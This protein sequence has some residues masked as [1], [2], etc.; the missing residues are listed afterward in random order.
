MKQLLAA[1]ANFQQREKG[2][3]D[4]I[5]HLAARHCPSLEILEYLV[6]S[7]NQEMLF[8]RNLKGDTPLSISITKG[9]QKAVDLL[10]RLQ[11][12]YDKTSKNTSDLMD[13]LQAEEQKAEREKQKRKDKKYR[14]KI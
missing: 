3:G 6:R 11:V 13:S 4:N 1:Q 9:N 10:E 5:L 14:Q 8:E 2:T 12:V 7:L